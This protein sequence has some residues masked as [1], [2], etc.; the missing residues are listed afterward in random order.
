M[1]KYLWLLA[2]ILLSGCASVDSLARN[3]LNF[4]SYQA[5]KYPARQKDYPVELFFE[6]RPKRNYEVIGEFIGYADNGE[7]VREILEARI[8]QVGGDAAIDIVLKAKS[9]VDSEIITVPQPT[10]R[11]YI[12]DVP[13]AQTY[14]YDVIGI[15]AKVIRYKE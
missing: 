10:K 1:R 13:V 12:R 4:V 3:R 6:G 14:V 15:E 5:T 9:K 8:R 7:Q 2:L 11:G